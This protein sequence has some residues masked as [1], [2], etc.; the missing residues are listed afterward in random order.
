MNRIIG[1]LIDII[2]VLAGIILTPW[3][4]F[5]WS[6]IGF[7]IELS[8]NA[9]NQEGNSFFLATLLGIALLAYGILDLLFL[10]QK[11]FQKDKNKKEEVQKPHR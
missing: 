9:G 3:A 10:R 1:R 11:K 5:K 4:I 2:L 6:E 8:I 7:R